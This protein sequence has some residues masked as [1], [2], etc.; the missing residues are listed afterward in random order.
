MLLA[1]A[2]SDLIA[3]LKQQIGPNQVHFDQLTR[4]L[5]STDA[6]NYQIMPVGVTF[7]RH[8]EDVVAIHEAANRHR[9]PVLP[10]G[11]G[12]SLAGQA[13]G[14]AI[15]MDFTRHMRRVT[16]INAEAKTVVVE[17]GLTLGL[18]NKQLAPL[19][20]MFGPDPASAQR[21]AVGGVV[22]NNSTGAHSIVYGMASDHISRLKVVLASGE[23]AWLDA[24]TST[25]ND[26]RANIAEIALDNRTEIERRYPKTFRTV[27]GYGLDKINPDA[28][29]LNS[30]V[31]G[32]EGTLATLIEI[33]LNLV[34][35]VAP[36]QRRLALVHFGSI[37]ESL[38]VTPRILETSPSAVELL[39]K[40]LLDRT[41]VNAE[42]SKYLTFVEGDPAAVLIVE[43]YGN[44]DT[45]LN[46]KLAELQALLKRIGHSKPVTRAVT[47]AQQ[48]AVWTVRKAGLGLLMSERS[49]E[50]PSAFI[51]DAAVPVERLAEY[52]TDIDDIIRGQNADYAIYAHASAGC[53]H[54]RPL[55]NLKTL[56]GR[57]QYRNIAEAATDTAIK[58]QGTITGEHGQGLARS[59]FVE[60]LFG[61]Q[62]TKA[63]RQIKQLFDPDNLMNPGKIVDPPPMDDPAILRYTP[64]YTLIQT[65]ETRFDWSADGGYAGAV[66]MCNGS[67][68]CR[69]EGTGTMCPSYM[70]TL[71]EGHVT[72]GRANALRQAL[73]GQ[74]PGGM[75]SDEVKGLMDL[76]L[77]CKACK[78]EC[79]S[80][81][82]LAKIKAEFMAAY[83]DKHGTPIKT[84]V[85]GNIHR[86]NK[87]ASITPSLSNM[88]LNSPIGK[89]TFNLLG[90]PTQRPLPQFASQRFS[91]QA[92]LNNS[93][94]AAATLIIDTFTEYNHPHLGEAFLKVVSALGLTV[95]VMRLP[96]QG[97]C[98]RPAMSRGLLD[99]AKSLA[100]EN[101][102]HLS[103]GADDHPL[104][105]LEPS[106][107][108]AFLDDYLTLVDPAMRPQA[109]Q[110][111]ARSISAERWLAQQFAGR[112]VAWSGELPER[113]LLHGHCHQKT[114]WGTADTLAMLRTIPD[115]AVEEIDSGCCGVAGSF[116]YEHYDL[117]IK[118]GEQ[119]LLPTIRDNPDAVIAAPGTSCRAQIDDV[120]LSAQHPIEILARALEGKATRR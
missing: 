34:E 101:I 36:D 28:V 15:V 75:A 71:D 103:D 88:M 38:E 60:R 30:L 117:S 110:V 52:I 61:P 73:S 42:F 50:K 64:D 104:L 83:H 19:G 97:C 95:N 18:L 43:Y 111:A 58:Y 119:R 44:D 107:Q 35:A 5:Y 91:K 23:T 49:E 109:E 78:S 1:T 93:D 29:D 74:L 69:K 99:L 46:H 63:F 2:T 45:E 27:A 48:S 53:L 62:I 12:S 89:A 86:I 10:R 3:D 7:P 56:K 79:P 67:G 68:V 59:E 96:G 14:E 66:E 4:H 33:E 22:G 47:P 80:S 20:L 85:F 105:F 54:V 11:G 70:A 115:V 102:K 90:I 16:S 17:P 41:R 77:S 9:I 100:H 13:V 120:G 8:A 116:G 24:N 25:L 84:R 87:L 32:S 112:K 65:G 114:L 72:R 113:I 82:D 108:S 118:I 55:L 6:S 37:I 81:V 26:I 76:C 92:Q 31:C 94:N 51:E 57:E 106:C 39:D 21:A 40:M 98:G